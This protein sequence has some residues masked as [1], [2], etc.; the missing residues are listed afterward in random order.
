[1]FSAGE[2]GQPVRQHLVGRTL[3][4]QTLRERWLEAAAGRG[5]LVF[6]SGEPGIGK[7]R[8]ARKGPEQAQC[9]QPPPVRLPRMA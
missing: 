2:T 5:Q 7:T 9:I 1:M 8:L 3:Q 6:I 4:L